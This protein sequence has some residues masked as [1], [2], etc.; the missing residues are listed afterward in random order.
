M[1]ITAI[2]VVLALSAAVVAA[3]ACFEKGPT[4]AD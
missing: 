3:F 4:Q 2:I 1:L